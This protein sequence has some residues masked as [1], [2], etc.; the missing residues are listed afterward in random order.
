[1]WVLTSKGDELFNLDVHCTVRVE[2]TKVYNPPRDFEVTGWRI[3]ARRREGMDLED[4]VTQPEGT[5]ATF[6][7]DEEAMAM[8]T[9]RLISKAISD[10][11]HMLDLGE[12]LGEAK[13]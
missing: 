6:G 13:S 2:P 5:L 8:K 10:G 9:L 4:G 11:V 3:E 1:M 12:Y 7:V